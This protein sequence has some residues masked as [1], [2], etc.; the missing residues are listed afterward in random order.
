MSE[1]LSILIVDDNPS[2]A[3]SLADVLEVKGYRVNV[4]SSGSDALALL[5][6]RPVDVLLTDVKMPNMDGLALYRAA[7]KDH[8]H[9]VTIF[10][11]A[12]AADDLIQ[13]GMAEGIKTV[14]NK[15]LDM[16]LLL[17]MFSAYKNILGKNG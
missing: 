4:A 6:T 3:V 9:L 2:M 10:M 11:T 17:M 12:Y 14:L 8:P 1:P 16:D 5:A 13:R 15:P 7:R